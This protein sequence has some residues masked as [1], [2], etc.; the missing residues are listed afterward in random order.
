MLF[1]NFAIV[2]LGKGS[3]VLINW[4]MRPTS[5]VPCATSVRGKGY[6]RPLANVAHWQLCHFA[7]GQFV[8]AGQLR[9]LATVPLPHKGPIRARWPIAAHW[10]VCHLAR[11]N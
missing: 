1:R 8:P 7:K 2:P 6:W 9:P 4:P 10:Q 5:T 11:A 3:V